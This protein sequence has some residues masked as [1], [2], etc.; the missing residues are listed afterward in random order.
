MNCSIAISAQNIWKYSRLNDER[1]LENNWLCI[2]GRVIPTINRI[3]A[4]HCVNTVING[5]WIVTNCFAIYARNITSVISATPMGRISFMREYQASIC[6]IS[7]TCHNIYIT[8][9]HWQR[10]SVIE[11]A[12]SHRTLSVRRGWMQRKY[13][14]GRLSQWHWFESAQGQCT[15]TDIK[16]SSHHRSSIQFG[17]QESCHIESARWSDKG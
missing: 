13:F 16:T 5:I 12:L 15:W 7:C 9:S 17:T 3:V 2:D 14:Y 1:T 10:S 8:Y 4:I 6:V 11:R